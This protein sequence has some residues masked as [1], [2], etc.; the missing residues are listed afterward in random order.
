MRELLNNSVFMLFLIIAIGK[1]IEQIKIKGF[2]LG[3]AS[4]FIIASVFGHYGFVLPQVYQT[5]ALAIFVYCVGVEAGPQFFTL[6]ARNS[7]RWLIVPVIHFMISAGSA[8]LLFMWLK[9]SFTAETFAG[10]YSGSFVST[11]AMASVG[12]G[13]TKGTIGAA[14]GLIYPVAFIGNIYLI[15]Y[16]PYIFRHNVPK[17]ISD[18]KESMTKM[19]P[20]RTFR[21]Y[22]VS[23]PNIIGKPFSELSSLNL[24]DVIFSRFV[25]NGISTLAHDGLILSEGGYV[26]AVGRNDDLKALELLIGPE[27]TPELDR[28]DQLISGKIIISRPEIAGK[29]LHELDLNNTYEV[30]VTR[31]IRGSV[32]LSPDPEKQLVLGDKVVVVGT[33]ESINRLTA[34]LGDDVEEIFKTQFAPVS[35]GIVLGMIAGI[36]PIPVIKYSLGATGGILLVSMFLG[37]RVKFL[38][39]LW[40]IPQQTNSFLKQLSLYIFFAAA[41]TNAGKELF[42]LF[43]G[44]QST[45]ILVAC[46]LLSFFPILATYFVSTSI[47][48]KNPLEVTGLLAGDLNGT[49]I[50][51]N[52]NETLKTDIPNVAFAFA[53]PIGLILAIA[54]TQMLYIL[55]GYLS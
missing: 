54:S 14:F 34:Y 51:L 21:F 35:I 30:R 39:I 41:G 22:K 2:S 5:F 46:V 15:P 16:L 33:K 1:L 50:L 36:V 3:I 42:D 48:K 25:L 11:P 12:A 44:P 47:L 53:Y 52:A 43:S 13:N 4:I 26:A 49:S 29:T 32:D 40:Q 31:I 37:Y 6:F 19:M 27:G 18:Y 45:L 17:L 55:L 20:V 24:R 7:R 8:V 9:G 23:N 28:M 10:L 38:N